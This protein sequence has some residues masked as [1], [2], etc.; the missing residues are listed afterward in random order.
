MTLRAGVPDATGAVLCLAAPFRRDRS[1]SG[2][3]VGPGSP[4]PARRA[5]R[6]AS[7][8]LPGVSENP[9]RSASTGR[10]RLPHTHTPHAGPAPSLP[11]N[12]R[13]TP[14]AARTT[15]ERLQSAQEPPFSIRPV[16][17][18]TCRCEACRDRRCCWGVAE[19][20]KRRLPT[21]VTV[22]AQMPVMQCFEGCQEATCRTGRRVCFTRTTA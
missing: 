17:S 11:Q 18:Q 2:L 7:L 20:G 3:R 16:L 10:R 21:L 9:G 12:R 15:D 5:R 22:R 1:R 13:I 8:G 19:S 4:A 6:R 14:S